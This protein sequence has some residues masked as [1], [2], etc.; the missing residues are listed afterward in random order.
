MQI[1]GNSPSIIVDASYYIF[2]RFFATHRWYS[3]QK[4]DSAEANAAG[5]EA[6]AARAE[7]NAADAEAGSEENTGEA[8]ITNDPAF[9]T[10][11]IKHVTQDIKKWR[12]TYSVPKGNIYF[13]FDCAKETIWRNV[14]HTN[15]KG[16]RVQSRVF[17]SNIFPVFFK[18]FDAEKNDMGLD[19]IHIEKLEADD[20]AYLTAKKISSMCPDMKITV[21]TNDNDYLQMRTNK[22]QIINAQGV[23]LEKRSIG[24]PQQD[25]L[26]KIILGDPSDNIKPICARLG[27]STAK[28]LALC[29]EH[30]RWAWI[31]KKGA[32]CVQAYQRNTQ[33]ISFDSIPQEYIDIWEEKYKWEVTA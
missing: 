3:F 5:A 23:N 9:V 13:C 7:A 8:G 10:A 22:I 4:K 33:M 19:A 25:L 17:D 18:W 15:Y 32:D 14:H 6:N 16:G 29:D 20:L 24:T 12:K 30:D 2:Y 27:E 31:V 21:I 1:Y 28:K 11:F 26:Y